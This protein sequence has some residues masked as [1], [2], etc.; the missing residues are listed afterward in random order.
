MKVLIQQA[1][2]IDPNS[3]HH[4]SKKDIF[5]DN[6]QIRQIADSIS[7]AADTVIAEPG[8]HASCG[9]ID[10]FAD[11]SDPGYEQK[12]TLETGSRAAAAGGFVTVMTI[13]NTKP[14]IDNK[15]QV[16]WIVRRSQTL[17]VN[18]IPLG[19]ITKGTEGKELAE[20]YDM[21]NGGARVF[22]DG[23]HPVQSA[24]ILLKALQYIKPFNGVI[25]QVPDDKT[26]V[27]HGLMHEGVMSTLLGLP[28]KP[29]LAE[30]LLVSRDIKLVEYTGSR[31]HF[32][33]VSAASSLVHIKAAKAAGLP[34]TCSVTPYHLLFCDE[35]LADYDAN[36]KVNPPLRTRTDMIALRQA[37]EEGLIDCIATHHS[38][39]DYDSKVLEFEYAKNGMTG[40]ETCYPA[41]KAALPGL[42]ET[43]IVELLSVH[44]ARIFNLPAFRIEVEQ[45]AL[46][47]LFNPDAEFI[48]GGNIRSKSVN[49]P[50]IGRKMQGNITGIINRNNVFLN[51]QT[52]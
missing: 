51:Q 1:V 27:P 8:L 18:I 49:S 29:A 35:D 21:H 44:A 36:L 16:E 20:M 25:I 47:T 38:P 5:I 19:A 14:A 46:I 45:P 50:L 39:Q 3:P 41:L 6:G 7:E 9:W 17:P 2:I 11:F 52:D 23:T 40:L 12:E 13:P 31:I 15:I 26:L 22:S 32:T 43:R 10:P 24:G 4:L 30:E 42:S 48:Y 28:G 33:A 37:V 34:V